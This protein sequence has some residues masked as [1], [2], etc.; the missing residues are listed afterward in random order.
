[1]AHTFYKQ[2]RNQPLATLAEKLAEDYHE[3]VAAICNM[4]EH[5]LPTVADAGYIEASNLVIEKTS[6]YIR[7]RITVLQP[8]ANDLHGKDISGQDCRYCPHRCGIDHAQIITEL[9]LLANHVKRGMLW[10]QTA[11][12][13]MPH[14][15]KDDNIYLPHRYHILLLDKTLTELFFLED[16]LLIPMMAGAQKNI[17]ANQ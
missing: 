16:T 9:Q 4:L 7:F 8:Y 2:Y 11:V 3:P 13:M 15:L 12:S 17:Y 14:R 5:T 10:L 6:D 1:M